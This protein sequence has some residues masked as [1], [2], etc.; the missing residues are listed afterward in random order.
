MVKIKQAE[1]IRKL[2]KVLPLEQRRIF[3]LTAHID[4]G[5]STTCDYLLARVGMLSWDLA[6]EKRLTDSSNKAIEQQQ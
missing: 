2:I 1:E 4:H 5:K 6:G 3:S